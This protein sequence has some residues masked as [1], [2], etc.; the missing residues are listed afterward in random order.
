MN[1]G[2]CYVCIPWLYGVMI[3]IS[4][5]TKHEIMNKILW[6]MHVGVSMDNWTFGRLGFILLKRLSKARFQN[7]DVN[8]CLAF[9][10]KLDF[11]VAMMLGLVLSI[12]LIFWVN[13]KNQVSKVPMTI[14]LWLWKCQWRLDFGLFWVASEDWTLVWK[15]PM[16]IGLLSWLLDALDLDHI[17][18]AR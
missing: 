13:H 2:L 9:Q 15:V 12:I 6:L 16:K 14:R 3:H 1:H 11:L 17:M 4:G 18:V 10:W 7:A 5:Y 8:S